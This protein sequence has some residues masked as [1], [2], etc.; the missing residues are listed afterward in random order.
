MPLVEEV[1]SGD[2]RRALV[3][4]R[5]RLAGDL[6]VCESARDVGTLAARLADVLEQIDALPNRAE[7]SAADEIAA[8]RASRRASP[9]RPARTTGA[10]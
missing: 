10:G 4:L 5:D 7:V 8:R 6:D 3:A 9:S 1:A 2:R